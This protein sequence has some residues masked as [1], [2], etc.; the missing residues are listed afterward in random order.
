MRVYVKL[1]LF[2]SIVF[3]FVFRA[4]QNPMVTTCLIFV[5]PTFSLHLLFPPKEKKKN[6][7][8]YDDVGGIT[9]T[10]KWIL[11]AYKCAQTLLSFWFHQNGHR[12]VARS[13]SVQKTVFLLLFLQLCVS[14]WFLMLIRWWRAIESH[15]FTLSGRNKIQKS[16]NQPK[17]N[18]QKQQQRRVQR[19]RKKKSIEFR[20]YDF[21]TDD[22]TIGCQTPPRISMNCKNRKK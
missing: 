7:D 5:L 19:R 2:E 11:C 16:N 1:W 17:G 8:N 9:V 12:A 6:F 4:I 14:N 22:F 3:D 21:P 15:D 18:R 20:D 13:Q 10:I